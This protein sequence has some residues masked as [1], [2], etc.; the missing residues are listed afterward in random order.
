MKEN[1]KL[2][3]AIIDLGV[4]MKELHTEMKGMRQEQQ[5]TNRRL[6]KLEKQQ[7]KTNLAIGELRISYMKVADEIAGLHSDFDGL[8]LEFSG[9]RSEFSGLRSDLRE[10]NA[11][12]DGLRSDFNKYANSNNLI[13]NEHEKRIIRLEDATF[14]NEYKKM[15]MVKEP[16]AIYK[17]NKK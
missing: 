5:E 12:L 11:K 8:R 15:S 13:I 6:E 16:K 9:L 14:D 4:G 7:A 17:R 10:T 3:D 2:L 1:N